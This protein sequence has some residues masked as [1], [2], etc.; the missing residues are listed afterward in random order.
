MTALAAVLLPKAAF[1]ASGEAQGD[2][3]DSVKTSND[4]DAN[5]LAAIATENDHSPRL[6]GGSRRP[7]TSGSLLL[8]EIRTQRGSAAAAAK[9]ALLE[10]D[11]RTKPLGW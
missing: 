2:G 7:P 8:M 3:S 4:T 9:A 1:A 5:S 10:L 6:A 11:P